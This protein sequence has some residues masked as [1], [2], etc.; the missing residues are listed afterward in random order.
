VTRNEYLE[1]LPSGYDH[2]NLDREIS[3]GEDSPFRKREKLRKQFA[4][5]IPTTHALEAILGVGNE[6]V[7]IGA[8]TG[9]WSFLLSE[10]G[11]TVRAYDNGSW[12]S[13]FTGETWYDV[14]RG[15]PGMLRHYPNAVALIVWPPYDKP[16]AFEVAKRIR[17]G[18][19]LVYVGEGSGGCTGDDAFFNLL[20]SD[21]ERI[22]GSAIPQWWGLHDHLDI[23]RRE[24]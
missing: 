19:Y 20:E 12:S 2:F 22:G 17:V 1:A 9:Y 11:A 23:Y 21:F 18:N 13:F 24:Q 5:A 8:G 6:I 4:F 10:M 15:G 7:E 3:E 14:R 16:M